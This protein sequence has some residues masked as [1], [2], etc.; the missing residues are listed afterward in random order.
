[1]NVCTTYMFERTAL[2]FTA[3]NIVKEFTDLRE[4]ERE[5]EREYLDV[6]LQRACIYVR[7]C[8]VYAFMR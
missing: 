1:M 6:D 5:I 4:T 8:I 2:S 3:C 7:V